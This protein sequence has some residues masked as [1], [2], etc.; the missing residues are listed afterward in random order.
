M[1]APTLNRGGEA[2]QPPPARRRPARTED[3]PGASIGDD[4][5]KSGFVAKVVKIFFAEF[6]GRAKQVRTA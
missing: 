6:F 5:V 4:A 2:D 1:F 3:P